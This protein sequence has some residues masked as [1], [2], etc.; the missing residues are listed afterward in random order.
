[1]VLG[2]IPGKQ[3]SCG[4]ETLLFDRFLMIVGYG[5]EEEYGLPVLEACF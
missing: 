4:G 3:N 5:G 2:E 1:M